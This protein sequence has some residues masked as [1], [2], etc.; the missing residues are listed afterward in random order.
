M[1]GNFV[2]PLIFFASRIHMKICMFLQES[3]ILFQNHFFRRR[4]NKYVR[5]SC[6][7]IFL[8]YVGTAHTHTHTHTLSLCSR[9]TSAKIT[10]QIKI[11][12][13]ALEFYENNCAF[14]DL[15]RVILI[16][17]VTIYPRSIDSHDD[18]LCCIQILGQIIH[19]PLQI[20]L[21]ACIHYL[22]IDFLPGIAK[23]IKSITPKTMRGFV[24]G[25]IYPAWKCEWI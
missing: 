5:L 20:L 9:I 17:G 15:I 18:I 23:L 25:A 19:A 7:E 2:L 1:C 11:S 4:F 8:L 12:A 21:A 10:K 3:C 6:S 22:C 24:P 16:E 13:R 14:F